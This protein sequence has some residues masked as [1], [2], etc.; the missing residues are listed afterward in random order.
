LKIQ[1]FFFLL[2]LNPEPD[3]FPEPSPVHQAGPER[4]FPGFVDYQFFASIPTGAVTGSRFNR[5]NR[6][7]RSGFYN[8]AFSWKILFSNFFF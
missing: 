6:P 2:K 7:V 4:F 3:G 8:I 5:S 1:F